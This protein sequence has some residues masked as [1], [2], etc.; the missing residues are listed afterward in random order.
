MKGYQCRSFICACEW[1]GGAIAGQGAAP[2]GRCDRVVP[3]CVP[4]PTRAEPPNPPN[5]SLP[6]RNPSF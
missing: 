4:Y 5:P 3:G 6:E 2:F 1:D